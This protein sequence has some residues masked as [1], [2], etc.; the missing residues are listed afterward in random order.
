MTTHF[1]SPI[2]GVVV[3]A[4][5][6]ERTMSTPFEVL[7][8]HLDSHEWNYEAH[9]D[10]KVCE[11]GFTGENVQVRI[12]LVIDE[13]DDLM[14]CF[15]I[16]PF[17]VAEAQRARICELICRMNFGLKVGKFE[18]DL[19]DGEVRH[20]ASSGFLAGVLPDEVISLVLAAVLLTTDRFYPAFMQVLFAGVSPK[21]ACDA[22][23][24]AGPAGAPETDGS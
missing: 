11:T 24:R 14:Q 17:R 13:D 19:S 3:H 20:H 12:F 21:D 9:E 2:L 5:H 7:K 23:E 4:D 1:T 18:L 8:R 15:A 10:R 16:L 6:K 22:I